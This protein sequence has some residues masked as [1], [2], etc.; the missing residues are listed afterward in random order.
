MLVIP[1]LS[2]MKYINLK[3]DWK[4]TFKLKRTSHT[5]IRSFLTGTTKHPM[6]ITH[7]MRPERSVNVDTDRQIDR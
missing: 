1:L 4:M 2:R 3:M 7:M 5:Y 6:R